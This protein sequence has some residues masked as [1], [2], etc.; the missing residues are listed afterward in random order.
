MDDFEIHIH[1][2]CK[3]PSNVWHAGVRF[4]T[5]KN[6]CDENRLT[7]LFYAQY[8]PKNKMFLIYYQQIRAVFILST[9]NFAYHSLHGL[10]LGKLYFSFKLHISHKIV[11]LPSCIEVSANSILS[12]LTLIEIISVRNWQFINYGMY[13][14]T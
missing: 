7:K 6:I 2:R 11:H 14:I 1:L 4:I 10:V 12:Q 3:N 8:K 5:I 9:S 13:K